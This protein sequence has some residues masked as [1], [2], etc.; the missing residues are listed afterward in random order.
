MKEIKLTQGKVALVNDEDYEWLNQ[1]K[2]L[3][4]KVRGIYYAKRNIWINNKRK[5][6]GMHRIIMDTLENMEVDHKDHDTL[7]N[8]RH[9]LRNCFHKQ[10]LRNQKPNKQSTSQYL[11]VYSNGGKFIAKIGVNGKSIYLGTKETL[12]QAVILRDGAAKKYSG[13]FAYLNF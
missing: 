5:L 4:H 6:V 10:N 1:W 13:E 2:W 9:N 8:Q 11:G 12:E 7:N 3:A